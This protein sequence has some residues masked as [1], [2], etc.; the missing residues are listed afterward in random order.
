MVE[1]MSKS[2]TIRHLDEATIDWLD[3]EARRRGTDVERIVIELIHQGA[4]TTTP[5]QEGLPVFHDLDALAGTWTQ[6]EAEEFLQATADFRR[7]DEA[8]WQ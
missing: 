2:I 4:K 3:A 6:E 8:L 5:P 1:D 7:V